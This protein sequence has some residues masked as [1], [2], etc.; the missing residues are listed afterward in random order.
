MSEK[1]QIVFFGGGPIALRTLELILSDFNIEAIVTRPSSESAMLQR[2]PNVPV[3]AL[4]RKAELDALCEQQRFTSRF[5][6]L[7]DFSVIVDNAAIASFPLGIINSHFSLLP[8][9]RGVDPITFAILSGQKR[10][11]V[12]I[13]QIVRAWDEGPLLAQA[14]YD[15]PAGATTATLSEDLT[16]LSAQMLREVVPAYAK[17][18]IVPAPQEQASIL[19]HVPA[20]YTHKLTKEDGKIDWSKPAE[21]LEREVRAYIGWP[22]SYTQLAG[23]DVIITEARVA[24]LSGKP[25]TTH[26]D[27]QHLYVYC[28]NDA[29][30]IIKLKPAGKA[31]MSAAAFLA[32]Y[33]Q[34]L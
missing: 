21:V 15:I 18:D 29:L 19:G 32:G 4:R 8:E 24:E 9:L 5:G 17:G 28:G 6:L 31:E 34:L 11:G 30:E 16:E 27:K 7:I 20:T 22:G 26:S 10:T 25:G 14:P 1:L 23:K 2:F 3:F 33:R 13:M 12:S